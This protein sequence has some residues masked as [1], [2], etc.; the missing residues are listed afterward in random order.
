MRKKNFKKF[1][2]ITMAAAMTLG[3]T[4]TVFAEGEGDDT[5]TTPTAEAGVAEGEGTYE[6]GEMKYPTLSVT[7]PTIPAGTYDYIADPNGLIE[8]T[9]NDDGTASKYADSTFTGTTGIFFLTNTAD[10][11]AKTYTEK[12]AALTLANENAQD[13]DVTVKLEQKTAGDTS[14]KY[15]NSAEFESTDKDNKLFLA[16]TDGA[17]TD[18][19]V[20]ALT[21]NGAATVTTRVAG[22]PENF[23][24]GYSADTGYGYTKKDEADLTDWND[25]SFELTG[26]LNKNATWGDDLAFPA[27]KVTWSYAEHRDSALSASTI[28]KTANTLTVTGATVTG[29]TLVKTSGTTAACAAG[30]NYTFADGKLTVQATMLANNIG[31]KLKIA[32]ST[33][34]TE[35]VTIQ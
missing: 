33:G 31:G 10:D 26:A 6:G 21:G 1:A 27:I 5:S 35:E 14:I 8:K 25:C 28:S 18:P 17:T 2:A 30:T 20:A 29:V 19:K 4:L 11:G 3:S 15:A 23:E 16:I 32:L 7:L 24:A 22:V 34:V 13:I 12:S 9:K